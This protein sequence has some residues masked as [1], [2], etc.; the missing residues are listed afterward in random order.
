MKKEKNKNKNKKKKTTTSEFTGTAALRV[1]WERAPGCRQHAGQRGD[2]ASARTV[3]G[4]GRR[5][6]GRTAQ[7][8][9]GW[10][11]GEERQ[12]TRRRQGRTT[13]RVSLSLFLSLL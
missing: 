11:A 7:P 5:G 4:R 8:P 3:A 9:H 1:P 6:L 10:T 13:L 12:K 2:G